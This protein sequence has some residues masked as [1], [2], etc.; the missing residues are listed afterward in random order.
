MEYGIATAPTRSS[1]WLVAFV[2]LVTGVA[3]AAIAAHQWDGRCTAGLELHRAVAIACDHNLPDSQ[4]KL[5]V[6]QLRRI[7][8]AAIDAIEEVASE[9]ATLHES[10]IEAAHAREH[11]LKRLT[12]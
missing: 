12:H 8:S 10:A 3:C 9:S 4:R 2:I 7:A 5:A 11:L 6:S 1:R